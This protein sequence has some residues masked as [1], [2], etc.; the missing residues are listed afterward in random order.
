MGAV[1]F[2]FCFKLGSDIIIGFVV[3]WECCVPSV[4]VEA[5]LAVVDFV[6]SLKYVGEILSWS[7]LVVSGKILVV[8][9]SS[10]EVSL[11]LAFSVVTTKTAI[12]SSGITEI[13]SRFDS[14]FSSTVIFC[15]SER[16]AA[17]VSWSYESDV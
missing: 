10:D 5:P 4:I 2:V 6:L 13:L 11:S 17:V 7:F 1:G 9:E 15:L 16:S 3:S 8:C 12:F 14:S